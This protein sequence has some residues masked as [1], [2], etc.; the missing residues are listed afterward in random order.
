MCKRDNERHFIIKKKKK[1]KKR[2]VGRDFFFFFCEGDDS[3]ERNCMAG[4]AFLT[5]I[6]ILVNGQQQLIGEFGAVLLHRGYF[7]TD[8]LCRRSKPSRLCT[9]RHT[10]TQSTPPPPPTTT[11]F[12][13]LLRGRRCLCAR[14]A[15]YYYVWSVVFLFFPFRIYNSVPRKIPN[16]KRETPQGRPLPI[17]VYYI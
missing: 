2:R 16:I 6:V 9:P 5:Y 14:S 10:H 1:I 15:V 17:L 4:V 11:F 13:S 7:V 12:S 8:A 3:F